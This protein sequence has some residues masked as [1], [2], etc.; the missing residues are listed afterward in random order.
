M[1]LQDIVNLT[2][3]LKS[4][5]PTKAGFGRAL[6]TTSKNKFTGRTKLYKNADDLLTDG[7][8]VNDIEWKK[9][10]ALKSQNPAPKDFK[11]GKRLLPPTQIVQLT[12]TV[13]TEGF[14]Y[15]GKI[16]GPGG[17]Q[18]F[19]Y[20][21]GA[22]AT[23]KIIVEA[24][25]PIIEALAD[26]T[27]TED[28]TKLVVTSSAAGKI[29]QFTELVPELHV[30]DA[31]TDPGIATDLA[32]ILAAD[33]DWF[34]LLLDSD[35]EAEIEA[36]A[37][38][39]ESKRKLFKA[40]TADFGAKDSGTT[41]DV[42]SDCKALD[43]FN[44]EIAYHHKVGSLLAAGAMGVELVRTP[45]TYTMAHKSIRGEETTGN[46]ANG[47][48]YLTDAQEAVVWGKNGNTYRTI[49]GNGDY[50]PAWVT[51]GDYVDAVRFI[52]F[53]F[54]RIQERVIGT[55]QNAEVIRFSRA[56]IGIMHTAILSLLQVWTKKPYEALSTEKPYEP[57][58]EFP[59]LAD[60]DDA[61]RAN[62]HLPDGTFFA[63]YTGAIHT[64]D[65]AGTVSV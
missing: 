53:M 46:H 51:G 4:S 12:P 18:S 52:H 50:F 47:T 64:M 63:R 10:N 27:C 38:W 15:S 7:Y 5:F 42:I 48:P 9:A 26:V 25:M 61:D 60:I 14:V 21:V 32:A 57:R 40:A 6:I 39:A 23:I 13:T 55:L 41:T 30:F 3:T 49:A 37:V 43:L 24:L 35:S 20:T 22:A 44:T 16:L 58:V 62:R 65:L 29:L 56:G 36:A 1:A 17:T 33:G 11:L 19:S 45:G 31:T 2:I 34:G 59:D 28:D 8:T 54:A